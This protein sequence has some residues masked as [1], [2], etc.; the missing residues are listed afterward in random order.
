MNGWTKNPEQPSQQEMTAWIARE[1]F[2]PELHTDD[3]VNARLLNLSF[4]AS[5]LHVGDPR[6]DAI[7]EEIAE[8]AAYLQKD[9]ECLPETSDADLYRDAIKF[10]SPM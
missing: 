7:Y 4:W 5:R 6:L 3:V 10:N 8:L 1:R 9:G 2:E